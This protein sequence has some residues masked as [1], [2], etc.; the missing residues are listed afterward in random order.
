MD[1]GAYS[2]TKRV[3]IEGLAYPISFT[4][5]MLS[6]AHK[7]AYKVRTANPVSDFNL[8]HNKVHDI[9]TFQYENE[10]IIPKWLTNDKYAE[11]KLSEAIAG[12]W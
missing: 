12:T 5:R 6:G 7:S 9:T 4:F 3:S 8:I 2:F 10:N 11:A 1:N